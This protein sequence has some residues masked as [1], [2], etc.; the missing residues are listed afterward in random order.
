[1]P[2]EHRARAA[3]GAKPMD[4]DE[5]QAKEEAAKEEKAEQEKMITIRAADY[6]ALQ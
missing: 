6:R 3:N 4:M 5:A 1:M 2:Q